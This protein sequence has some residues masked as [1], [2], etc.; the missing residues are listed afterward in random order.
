[1]YYVHLLPTLKDRDKSF[2][3]QSSDVGAMTLSK[4]HLSSVENQNK[5]TNL[6]ACLCMDD[7][8][9]MDFSVRGHIST[10]LRTYI[11]VN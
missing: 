5:Q 9:M 10:Y 6:S 7:S 1:M 8:F 4:Q 11:Q 3:V 2:C